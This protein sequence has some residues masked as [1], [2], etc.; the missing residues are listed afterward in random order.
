MDLFSKPIVYVL[1]VCLS[2][3][4]LYNVSKLACI[5]ILAAYRGYSPYSTSL[6]PH[7]S[8]TSFKGISDILEN[9]KTGRKPLVVLSELP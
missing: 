7:I 5:S 8:T 3:S 2:I 9:D 6:K 1:P 4:K